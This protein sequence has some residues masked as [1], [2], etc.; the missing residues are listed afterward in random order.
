MKKTALLFLCLCF[1]SQTWA[2]GSSSSS[3]KACKKPDFSNFTP[4]HLSEIPPGSAFNFTTN[5]ATNTQSLTV[6]VKNQPVDIHIEPQGTNY[7]I[8]GQLPENLADTYAR[9]DINGKTEQGCKGQDGWLV[10]ITP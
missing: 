8:S 10:K 5:N 7:K 2:Y 3:K 4:A 6:T 9:I 1:S